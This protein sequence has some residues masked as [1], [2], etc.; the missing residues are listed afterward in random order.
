[1]ASLA[2]ALLTAAR[3]LAPA[4][5]GR[6]THVALGLPPCGFLR[7]FGLPCPTCGLTTSFAEL[8]RFEL[9]RSLRAHP[10][11]FPLFALTV[12][13]VPIALRTALRGQPLALVRAGAPRWAALLVLTLLATWLARLV[14]LAS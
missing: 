14:A 12:L 11:G 7:W 5:S 8:A 3:A 9:A 2:L 1:M 13:A 6:G 10:L 4:P